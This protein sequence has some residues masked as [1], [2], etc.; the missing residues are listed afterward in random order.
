MIDI[1][2]ITKMAESAEVLESV[3]EDGTS[4]YGVWKVA[5]DTYE[6]VGLEFTATSQMFYNYAKSGKINGTKSST[7][8]YTDDE[9]EYFVA[10]LIAT[11]LKK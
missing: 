8:R 5:K 6:A 11:E 7:Q 3:S 10:R 4:A 9:V 1:S 2:K